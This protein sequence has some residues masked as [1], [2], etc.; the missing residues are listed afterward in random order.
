MH[1]LVFICWSSIYIKLFLSDVVY[2]QKKILQIYWIIDGFS[3]YYRPDVYR[4]NIRITVI[5]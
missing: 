5:Q 3:L 2:K 1:A 4:P